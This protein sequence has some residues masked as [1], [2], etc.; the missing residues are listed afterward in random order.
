MDLQQ[1]PDAQHAIRDAVQGIEPQG[2]HQAISIRQNKQVIPGGRNAVILL[3]QAGLS[4]PTGT[5]TG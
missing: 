2:S 1:K 4:N 5:K 3:A